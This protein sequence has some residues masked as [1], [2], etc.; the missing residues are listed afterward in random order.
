MGE[1]NSSV[2][3]V[4]SVFD[5]LFYRDPTGNGMAEF[6]AQARLMRRASRRQIIQSNPCV[7]RK[8]RPFDLA[9]ESLSL[10]HDDRA[11]V[12]PLEA[13]YLALQAQE[14]T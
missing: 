9:T 5:S 10:D 12:L 1:Y 4:W 6:T 13:G 3:R 8:R 7:C 11:D 2:T 14:P